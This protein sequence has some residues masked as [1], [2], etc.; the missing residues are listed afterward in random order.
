MGGR[1]QGR[2]VLL[3]LKLPVTL[4]KFMQPLGGALSAEQFFAKWKQL[5]GYGRPD[6]GPP[7]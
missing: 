7:V 1:Y 3:T 6:W 4:N 2:T 5:G